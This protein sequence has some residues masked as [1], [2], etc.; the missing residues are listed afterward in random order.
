MDS[1]VIYY[2][3]IIGTEGYRALLEQRFREAGHDRPITFKAWDCY[4][5]VPEADGD[6]Y[7]YDA[8]VLSAL[9]DK[10][11]LGVL[12]GGADAGDVFGWVTAK[13]KVRRRSYGL[14]VML[15]SNA[16]IC[17]REDDRHVRNIMELDEEAAI[18]LRSMLMYYF[19]QAFCTNLNI[20]KSMKVMEHLI[21]LIGGRDKLAESGFSDY[22]GI[23]RFNRGECRYFLGYTENMAYMN[24]DEYVIDFVNFSEKTTD[25]RPHFFADFVSMGKNVNQEKKQDCIDLMNIMTDEQFVYDV[26][27]MDGKLQ[28]ML[29]AN[30]RVFPRLAQIDPLYWYLF[31]LMESEENGVLRYTKRFYEDFDKQKKVLIQF[32]WEKAGW[33]CKE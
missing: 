28:Y 19:V 26:C 10:G 3:N 16:L 4:K 6:L 14:P 5:D 23:A 20:R 29:P 25:R 27:N 18:P 7:I 2:D 13:S 33:N 17:R 32:L 15:C 31:G 11:I 12:P 1:I 8:I 21:D 30:R 24:E 22:E 9:V